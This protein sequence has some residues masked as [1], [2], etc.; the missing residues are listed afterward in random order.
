ML[1]SLTCPECF[2]SYVREDQNDREDYQSICV[3]KCCTYCRGIRPRIF[4]KTMT[5]RY[6]DA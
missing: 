6:Q 4:F 2:L 3:Y 1:H 5:P